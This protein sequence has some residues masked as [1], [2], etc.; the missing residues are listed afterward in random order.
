MLICQI[1]QILC[2]GGEAFRRG[3]GFQAELANIRSPT[4][5]PMIV[6]KN[7]DKAGGGTRAS[8]NLKDS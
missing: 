7:K 3:A 6:K 2:G 1:P 8:F 5:S 4:H